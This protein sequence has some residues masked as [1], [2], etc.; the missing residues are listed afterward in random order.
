MVLWAATRSAETSACHRL[1]EGAR[2]FPGRPRARTRPGHGR[3]SQARSAPR[4]SLRQQSQRCPSRLTIRRGSRVAWRC[5]YRRRRVVHADFFPPVARNG[6]T[7][8]RR[9]QGRGPTASPREVRVEAMR[10]RTAKTAT[11]SAT[12]TAPQN[13]TNATATTASGGSP[14]SPRMAKMTTWSPRMRQGAEAD[15]GEG[16]LVAPASPRE[17]GAPQTSAGCQTGQK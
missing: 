15:I 3:A 10:R 7:S 17:I 1:K 4:S 16:L 6:P 2:P 8:S 5:G 11:V 14:S 12:R 9:D 13:S